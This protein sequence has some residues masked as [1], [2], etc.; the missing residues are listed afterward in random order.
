MSAAVR[1]SGDASPELPSETRSVL[2]VCLGNICRSPLARG[3]FM[4]MAGERGASGRFVVDSC[5][6]G[7][8]HVG[9][10]ADPRTHLVARKH[11]VP[12]THRARQLAPLYD[13]GRFDLML[14]MDERNVQDML[15]MGVPR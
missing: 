15:Q 10:D 14:A 9:S 4:H 6:T 11:Q 7:A 12:M 3:V 5:G 2:F 1:N 8:W 13:V